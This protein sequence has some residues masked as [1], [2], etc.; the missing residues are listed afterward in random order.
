M[1]TDAQIISQNGWSIFLIALLALVVLFFIQKYIYLLDEKFGNTSSSETNWK[2]KPWPL[3]AALG[4]GLFLFAYNTF[5]PVDLTID[6]KI[7]NSIKLLLI[8]ISL[9][10]I[11][12]TAYESYLHFGPKNGTLRTLIYSAL[13]LLYFFTGLFTGYI[14]MLIVALVVII[15]FFMYFKKLLT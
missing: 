13:I 9:A 2:G 7:Q 8:I 11:A 5:S 6:F 1:E 4:T 12:G 14:L 3:F 15:W 10:V